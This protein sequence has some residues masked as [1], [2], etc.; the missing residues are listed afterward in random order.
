M[1]VIISALKC[2]WLYYPLPQYNHVMVSVLVVFL[3]LLLIKILSH[4]ML[5]RSLFLFVV[6]L[7]SSISLHY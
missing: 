3:L 7:G 4:P 6:F 1:T 5:E 2:F